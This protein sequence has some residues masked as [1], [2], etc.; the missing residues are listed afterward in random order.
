VGA[1]AS[2]DVR[3]LSEF[4]ALIEAQAL[5]LEGLLGGS[6]NGTGGSDDGGKQGGRDEVVLGDLVAQA[7]SALDALAVALMAQRGMDAVAAAMV[8]QEPSDS[9]PARIA[10]GAPTGNA[11]AE[12]A[13]AAARALVEQAPSETRDAFRAAL[14]QAAEGARA[15]GK[16]GEPAALE[17]WLGVVGE[18]IR[19]IAETGHPPRAEVRLDVPGAGRVELRIEVVGTVM[20]L[21]LHVERQEVKDR[22]ASGLR[23]LT[24]SLT[25]RGLQLRSF[26][27]DVSDDRAWG[28]PGEGPFKGHREEQPAEAAPAAKAAQ[29]K[30]KEGLVDVVA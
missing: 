3:E 2:Q 27:L 13:D 12:R 9:A 6:R 5:P 16:L 15:S 7:S 18:R 17:R 20:R 26:Q 21:G 19:V 4:A 1:D 25:Q 8:G 10:E 23:A 29:R 24:D 28:R 11:P 30:K 14:T 22:F